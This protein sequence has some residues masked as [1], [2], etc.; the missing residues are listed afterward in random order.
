MARRTF[1]ELEG[2]FT[3]PARGGIA[4]SL[5]FILHG[6]GADG[7]DL[8][9]LAYP[10]SLRLPGAAFFVPN[11][12]EP[13]SM[14]PA[15]RQWFEIDDREHGPVKAAPIIEAAMG[16]AS[17][18]LDLPLSAMVL[19][20]FSQGGM[21][22]LHCGLHMADKPAAIVSFSGAL[23]LHENLQPAGKTTYPLVQLVHG[24]ADAVVPFQLMQAA[25]EV[26]RAKGIE[27]DTV[28]RPN[29]GHGID[30]D[31]LSSAIDFLAQHL[32]T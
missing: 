5:I 25:A 2:F 1:G 28:A 13:C 4:S 11:A 30:P 26:L 21:M 8:A 10:I 16:A 32:P 7:A 19:C 22:S 27:V 18:E 20:G 29:L 3:A 23:L 14:N 31:G 9:D 15:G 12:P 24:T 6:W 17:K